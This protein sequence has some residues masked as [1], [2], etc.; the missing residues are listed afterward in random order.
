M[1]GL[2]ETEVDPIEVDVGGG[3][4]ARGEFYPEEFLIPFAT[5]P[6]AMPGPLDRRPPRATDGRQPPVRKEPGKAG[7]SRPVVPSPMLSPLPLPT[8][9]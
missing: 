9:A 5:K 4:G 6:P 1:L 2:C 8:S 3:V 7:S